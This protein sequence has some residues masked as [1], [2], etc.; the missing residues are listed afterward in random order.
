MV[1]KKKLYLGCNYNGMKQPNAR[2]LLVTILL[3][4]FVSCKKQAYKYVYPVLSDGLYDSEFP[5]KN[6]S[7]QLKK[8][9]SSITKLEAKGYYLHHFFCMQKL[10]EP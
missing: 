4:F 8:I 2:L 1:G 10:K 5:Y 3:V 6:C 7:M 9:T